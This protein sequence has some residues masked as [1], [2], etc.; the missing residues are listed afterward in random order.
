M[1]N[2]RVQRTPHSFAAAMPFVHHLAEQWLSIS[3]SQVTV[4]K[5]QLDYIFSIFIS[6]PTHIKKK[7]YC[8]A[9]CSAMFFLIPA[10]A[11]ATYSAVLRR[12]NCIRCQSA[13][14]ELSTRVQLITFVAR[15][16]FEIVAARRTWS[17]QVTF[18]FAVLGWI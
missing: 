6:Y 8:S 13:F 9:I 7:N 12:E 11:P 10:I 17:Y 3:N 14:T 5:E 15:T 1:V 2:A 16:F 4:S 18:M